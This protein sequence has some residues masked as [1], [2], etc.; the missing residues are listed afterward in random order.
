MDPELWD[1]DPHTYCFT[2]KETGFVVMAET[3]KDHQLP[4][5]V[6]DVHYFDPT[7]EAPAKKHTLN[8]ID[9]LL[10][11][12]YDL[13]IQEQLITEEKLLK[14][15]KKWE[16]NSAD[17][18]GDIKKEMGGIQ[19]A[20]TTNI[21]SMPGS[22]LLNEMAKEYEK[23]LKAAFEPPHLGYYNTFLI[24]GPSS[25]TS[26][27]VAR[28]LVLQGA[29]S[30]A[31][32]EKVPYK[33]ELNPLDGPLEADFSM[34]SVKEHRYRVR[35]LIVL[36]AVEQKVE[37]FFAVGLHSDWFTHPPEQES[38]IIKCLVDPILKE[39]AAPYTSVGMQAFWV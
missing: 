28:S 3:L 6:Y 32:Q 8:S 1:Y 27:E 22:A 29:I 24:G 37:T 4:K 14:D 9:N 11:D 33:T 21:T 36:S 34:P 26:V 15:L 20:I 19:K 30:V 23:A 39:I 25:M 7:F 5:T 12:V 2:H 17:P 16:A 38:E 10:K 35:R 18:V 13:K 31:V